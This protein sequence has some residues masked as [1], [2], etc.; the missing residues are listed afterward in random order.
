MN[1]KKFAVAG[2]AVMMLGSLSVG[3]FASNYKTPTEAIAGITGR[4]VESVQADRA[5]G[6]TYCTIATDAGKLEEY[7]KEMLSIKKDLLDARVASGQLTKAQADEIYAV[8][9]QRQAA[10]DGTACSQGNGCGLGGGLGCGVQQGGGCGAQG[11]GR[12]MGIGGMGLRD[13]SCYVA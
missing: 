3:A 13:G 10:C 1:L 5:E 8:I 11:A 6:K 9:E 2:L 12:G 4:S 7:Q